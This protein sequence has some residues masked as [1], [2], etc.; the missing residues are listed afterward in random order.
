MD[1]ILTNSVRALKSTSESSLAALMGRVAL[2]SGV[3]RL[4]GV[5]YTVQKNGNVKSEPKYQVCE[6]SSIRAFYF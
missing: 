2:V 1:N 3:D 5:Q 6:E 4:V